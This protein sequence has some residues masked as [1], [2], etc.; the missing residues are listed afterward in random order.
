M[1]ERE[2]IDLIAGL[3]GVVATTAGEGDGTAAVAQGDS[4]FRYDPDGTR[5]EDWGANF[6]T[7]VT[8]DYEGF[9]TASELD[10]PGVSG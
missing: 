6:A 2:M 10:R 9:D 5:A 7:V 8:K 4:F 1:D 3:P